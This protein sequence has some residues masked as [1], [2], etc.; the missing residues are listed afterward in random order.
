MLGAAHAPH[1]AG[2]QV[3]AYRRGADLV[4]QP[5]GALGGIVDGVHVHFQRDGHAGTLGGGA[6]LA[7]GVHGAAVVVFRGR[8]RAVV[9]PV[10]AVDNQRASVA[11]N[12]GNAVVRAT[13]DDCQQAPESRVALLRVVADDVA[14]KIEYGSADADLAAEALGLGQGLL[15]CVQLEVAAPDL[16]AVVAVLVRPAHGPL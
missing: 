15:Y 11:I 10:L 5:A 13:G 4:Q 9:G 3:G 1:V 6:E 8:R 7:V 2:V 12:N 14:G 16:H